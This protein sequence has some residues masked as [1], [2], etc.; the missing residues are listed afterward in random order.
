MVGAKTGD[1]EWIALAEQLRLAEL[2][3]HRAL[4]HFAVAERRFFGLPRRQRK[5]AIPDWYTA[6]QEAEA[7]TVDA[8]DAIYVQIAETC[9]TAKA[10]LT[11]KL[12]LLATAH[13]LRSGLEGDNETATDLSARLICSLQR[14]VAS[15]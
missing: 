1:A 2:Q 15:L 10:G 6:A 3:L 4:D 12:R 13:G 11:L 7:S 9:V 14:D 8:L 5:R